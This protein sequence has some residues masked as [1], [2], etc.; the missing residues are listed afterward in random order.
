MKSKLLW[1]PVICLLA[2]LAWRIQEG[3]GHSV[4]ADQGSLH[5]SSGR[6][7]EGM[8]FRSSLPTPTPP[9]MTTP[10]P[11]PASPTPTPAPETQRVLAYI[12]QREG[13]PL[14]MIYP[15]G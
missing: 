12:A 8:L 6:T 10:A 2:L 3:R 5:A 13:I 7:G 15:S 9:V 4:S 1:I 11:V 14:E